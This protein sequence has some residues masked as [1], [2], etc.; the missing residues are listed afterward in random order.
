MV[1]LTS[2]NSPEYQLRA[3]QCGAGRFFSKGMI[4]LSDILD[5]T[6]VLAGAKK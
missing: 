1:I 2:Y 3:E 6:R 4:C 5:L